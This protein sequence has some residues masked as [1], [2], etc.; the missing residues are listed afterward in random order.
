M[1]DKHK[2]NKFN[3][4][5]GHIAKAE[6]QLK[7]KISAVDLIVELLDARIPQASRH[8]DLPEWAKN[9][10]I[11]TVMNKVDLAD[12]MKVK[13]HKFLAIN[14]KNPNTIK[15]LVNEIEIQSQPALAKLKKQ[16]IV[17]RPIRVMVVGYPNVGKSSLIN[18]LARSKKAKVADQAGVTRQQQWI[19]VKSKL[20]LK[21]LDTPG[22]IPA[23]F[24]SEE[25][26]LRLALCNCLGESAFDHLLIAREGIAL[27]ESLYPD[28]V[29]RHYK[30]VGFVPGKEFLLESIAETKSLIKDGELDINRA[31]E[32]FLHDFREARIGKFSLE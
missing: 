32:L 13:E 21:L 29:V 26:A 20:N 2:L 6:R 14:C 30:I 5:P 3:W 22:I 19:D 11:I 17:G 31:A 25:Q 7:E 23:Q 12:P 28:A 27:L 15:A 9:K 4:Y 10:P 8:K 16:G 24:Y 18:V 1:S